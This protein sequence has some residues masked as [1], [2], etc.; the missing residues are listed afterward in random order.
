MIRSCPDNNSHSEYG[1]KTD[2]F[3]AAR[4]IARKIFKSGLSS[5]VV[6]NFKHKQGGQT[7]ASLVSD[8]C[9]QDAEP[10]IN[11][12]SAR[13]AIIHAQL[14]LCSSTCRADHEIH[15]NIA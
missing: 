11:S 3:R 6:F 7:I 2:H 8:N 1:A 15:E 13:S 14:K 5:L 12:F 4:S 9:M 10:N